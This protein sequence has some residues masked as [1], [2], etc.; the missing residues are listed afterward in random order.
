[1]VEKTKSKL[2]DT[3]GLPQIG[4]ASANIPDPAGG[5]TVDAEA[6]AAIVLILAALE[7]HGLVK[8]S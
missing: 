8:A 4:D 5:V 3:N 6:R 2:A 7:Y 1:M